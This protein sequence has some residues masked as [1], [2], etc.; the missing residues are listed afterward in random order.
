MLLGP[1]K[2]RESAEGAKQFLL[3]TKVLTT[4]DLNSEAQDYGYFG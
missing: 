2:P 3:M 4:P 1:G